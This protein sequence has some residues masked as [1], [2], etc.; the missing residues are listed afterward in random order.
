[1]RSF[2]CSRPDSNV[3][4]SPYESSIKEF[5][6]LTVKDFLVV[7][8]DAQSYEELDL[9]FGKDF[10]EEDVHDEHELLRPG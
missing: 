5:T 3:F 4:E 8:V 7:P 9:T 10:R 1:M 2:T 6:E